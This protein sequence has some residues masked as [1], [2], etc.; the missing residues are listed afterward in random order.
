MGQNG[1]DTNHL[2]KAEQVQYEDYNINEGL[3]LLHS[4]LSRRVYFL[5][6]REKSNEENN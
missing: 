6:E 4:I 2:I 5:N 1:F 3:D